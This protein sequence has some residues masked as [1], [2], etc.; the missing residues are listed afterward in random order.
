ML[1][2]ERKQELRSLIN[3]AMHSASATLSSPSPSTPLSRIEQYWRSKTVPHK[4]KTNSGRKKRP[5]TAASSRSRTKAKGR[6]A[7]PSRSRMVDDA[8]LDSDVAWSR[9]LDRSIGFEQDIQRSHVSE[10]QRRALRHQRQTDDLHNS[11][12]NEKMSLKRAKKA[13]RLKR[14]KRAQSDNMATLLPDDR[15]T[16]GLEG[17]ELKSWKIIM[18][19]HAEVV[20]T[21][22]VRVSSKLERHVEHRRQHLKQQSQE[23]FQNATAN[24]GGMSGNQ[25]KWWKRQRELHDRVVNG[26]QVKIDTVHEKHVLDEWKRKKEQRVEEEKTFD[27][28]DG[29]L[30]GPEKMH[31]RIMRDRHDELI[32]DATKTIDT[33]LSKHVLEYREALEKKKKGPDGVVECGLSGRELKNWKLFQKV[34]DNIIKTATN[35]EDTKLAPHAARYREERMEKSKKR[36]ENYDVSSGGLEGNNIMWGGWVVVFVLLVCIVGRK[37]LRLY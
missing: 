28:N 18:K 1:S 7:P 25:L 21:A 27:V 6:P 13:A 29:G 24:D 5:H 32:A 37:L 31:W 9:T 2:P 19:R 20:S 35:R 33:T 8:L 14:L 36:F 23:R 3:S 11:M 30:H 22:N 16:G 4:R 34:H 15:T 12:R 10:S 17:R 26:A